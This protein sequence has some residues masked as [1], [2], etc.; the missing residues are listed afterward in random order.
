METSD[1]IDIGAVL[2]AGIVYLLRGKEPAKWDSDTILTKDLGLDSEDGVDL[3]CYLSEELGIEIPSKVN[4]LI[5]LESGHCRH[6]T[7]SETTAWLAIQIN[8]SVKQESP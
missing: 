3:A 6:R 2:R 7:L 5:G 4:P 8:Q 1:A